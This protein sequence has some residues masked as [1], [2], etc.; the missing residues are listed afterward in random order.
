LEAPHVSETSTS[1]DISLEFTCPFCEVRIKKTLDYLLESG[2]R[3]PCCSSKLDLD[4]IIKGSPPPPEK[5]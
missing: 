1:V 2:R 4:A 3:C 5:S